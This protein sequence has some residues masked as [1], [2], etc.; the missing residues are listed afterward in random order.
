[1]VDKNLFLYDLAVVTIMKNEAPYV[2]EWLDY[3]LLAGVDHFYIYDNESP[4]NLKEVLQPY[5]D[6]ELVTYT[7]YPGKCRQLEAY[8]DAVK[9]YKYFCRYMAWIDADEFI[10]P[11][12]KPTITEV[13]DDIL[14]NVPHYVAGLGVNL[15]AYGSNGMEKADLSR[16]VLERF[17]R[18]AEN[19]WTPPLIED[20]PQHGGNA[21]VSTNPR[22][23]KYFPTPHAPA[24]FTFCAAI[25]EL[26]NLVTDFSSFPVSTEKIVMNHYSVKS[27]EEYVKKISRGNADH[28]ENTYNMDNFYKYDRNE[29]F[30]DSILKY[31][32]ARKA[33]LIS[34]GGMEAVI[35]SKP[36]D[37]LR[38]FNTMA[39][40]LL[41]ALS[42]VMPREFFNNK[43]E[44]FLT[45]LHLTS[46]LKG[47]IFDDNGAKIFEEMSL[48]VLYKSLFAEVQIAD[49]ELLLKEMPYI[50]T[51]PYPVVKDIY[52]TLI[53]FL[54]QIL[55]VFRMQNAWQQFTDLEHEIEMLKNFNDVMDN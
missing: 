38:I 41:P 44:N 10:F 27:K 43:V 40:N 51:K 55:L 34:A 42:T 20:S 12:S 23:V 50:L 4:D 46:Y 18:R 2:K 36:I 37:Y 3:H 17:T 24:Y 1:M 29:V 45:C 22:R 52:K 35:H 39:Q 26:G 19:D 6:A 7:F 30:D 5:I 21:H 49:V 28:A 47:K 48:M 9:Q 54:P 53:R 8:I 33:A 14:S 32:D 13:A 31:R 15:N 11:K 16:S 25:N